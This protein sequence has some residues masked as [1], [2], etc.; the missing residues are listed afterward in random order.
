MDSITLLFTKRRF[1]PVSWVIRWAIP[2]SRFALAMSSHCLI[3]G[4]DAIYEASMLHG[5]RRA[6]RATALAGLTTVATVTYSIPSRAAAI[7]WLNAQVGKPY[8]W[9]GAFG[10]G[11]APYRDW[12]SDNKWFC[13]ELG[14][15]ALRAAGRSVFSNLG[16]VG[17]TAL[18]AIEP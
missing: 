18:M 6:D 3:D 16:H 4:G 5:V 7:M 2:R 11:L 15:G 17:E 9:A 12:A 1:N 13:Y 10:L 14:A 8:D